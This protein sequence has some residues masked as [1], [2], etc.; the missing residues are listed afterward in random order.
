MHNALF[1]NQQMLHVE[2]LKNQAQSLNLD[3]KAFVACL[4]QARHAG[5]VR[6]DEKVAAAAGVTGTPTFFIGK[7]TASGAIDGARLVGAQPV[8]AFR[9]VIDLLLQE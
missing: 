7:A 5:A 4:D 3:S 1:E 9:R 6:E 2:G 8:A